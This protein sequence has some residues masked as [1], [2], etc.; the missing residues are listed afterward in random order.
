MG[1][2]GSGKGK[3]WDSGLGLRVGVSSSPGGEC[4]ASKKSS[5]A[6]LSRPGWD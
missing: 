2:V 5:G 4:F 6:E 3:V 1:L